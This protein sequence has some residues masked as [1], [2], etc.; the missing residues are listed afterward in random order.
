MA[1]KNNNEKPDSYYKAREFYDKADWQL[2][3]RSYQAFFEAINNQNFNGIAI[4]NY[5][6]DDMMDPQYADPLI[7]MNFSIRN[8]PAEDI[9]KKW[10]KK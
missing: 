5:W 4:N 3:A 1:K 10:F 9:V 6:W 7:S 8:K 2:Q